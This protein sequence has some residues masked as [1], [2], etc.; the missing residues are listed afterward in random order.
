MRKVS[1]LSWA[2]SLDSK[3]LRPQRTGGFNPTGVIPRCTRFVAP[4]VTDWAVGGEPLVTGAGAILHNQRF[5]KRACGLA[6]MA[7]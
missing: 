6:Q 4:V 5:L 3:I 2:L 1:E 7:C